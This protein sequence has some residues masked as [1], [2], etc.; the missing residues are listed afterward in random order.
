MEA[1]ETLVRRR[2]DEISMEINAA[3][4]QF[5]MVEESI[6]KK[7]GEVFETLGEI[8]YSGDGTTAANTGVELDAV[9]DM[10]E[11][12]ATKIMDAAGRISSWTHQE[13]GWNTEDTRLQYIDMIN[14]EVEEIF[15]AC[16]FQDITSQRIRKTLENINKIEERLDD[17]LERMGVHIEKP[18][19]DLKHKGA[20]QDD[21]DALFSEG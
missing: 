2:F 16:S 9:V 7:F 15:L 20:S 21:I 19:T 8:S 14:K 5:G 10:T 17:A 12:A 1:F 18:D 11:E 3:S 4:Q 6:G 13:E